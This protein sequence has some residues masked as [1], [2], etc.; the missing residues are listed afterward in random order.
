MVMLLR[1]CFAG[2]AAAVAGAGAEAVEVA[3]PGVCVERWRRR[4][5]PVACGWSRVERVAPCGGG[6]ARRGRAG[7]IAGFMPGLKR[8]VGCV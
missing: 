2:G 6:I 1:R 8:C 5:L 7:T 4:W 3:V